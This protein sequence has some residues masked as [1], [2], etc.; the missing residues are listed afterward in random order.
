MKTTI[1]LLAALM[2]MSFTNEPVNEPMTHQ[3]VLYIS[4]D[5]D[6]EVNLQVFVKSDDGSFVLESTQTLVYSYVLELNPT[7][8]YQL[9]F[10]NP[11]GYKKIVYVEKGKKGTWYRDFDVHFHRISLTML[12]MYLENDTYYLAFTH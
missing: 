11:Y 8:E 5:T 1:I 10:S 9:W 6:H 3:N 2:S 12:H 7:K 4:G